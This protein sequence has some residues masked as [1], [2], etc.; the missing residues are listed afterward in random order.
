MQQQRYYSLD[1]F[2]GATVALMILVNN[3]GSWVNIYGPLKHAPWHGVT[4]TDLVF[5]FSQKNGGY[6][7]ILFNSFHR[8]L[9]CCAIFRNVQG[10]WFPPIC[11][12]PMCLCIVSSTPGQG[13][14]FEPKIGEYLGGQDMVGQRAQ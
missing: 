6:S 10:H 7:W 8:F 1:V 9:Q 2:R 11:R 14:V 12:L 4:P 13:V 5:P 3:P